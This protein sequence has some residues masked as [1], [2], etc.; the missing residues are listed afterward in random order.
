MD[1]LDE[2]EAFIRVARS[3]SFTG[4]ARERGVTPSALSKQVKALESRLGVRLLQ[5]TTRRV[6]LTDAGRGF[7]ERAETIVGDIE[8][9][10]AAVA[11]LDAEPRGVLR[12]GAPMDFGR[13]HLASSIASF[14]AAHPALQV[15]VELTDRAVD[16][17]EEGLDVDVRIGAL[18]ESSLVARRLAPCHRVVC[19]SP[20]Y[21]DAHG[22][23]ERVE[24]FAAYSRVGYAYETQRTWRFETPSGPKQVNVPVGHRANNGEVTRALLIEGLGVALLPTF[25]VADAVRSGALEMLLAD[26]VTSSIPIHALYPH[27]KQ[28]SAKVRAFVDHLVTHCGPRPY[29]DDG[30][31]LA[32][33]PA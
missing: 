13:L 26:R 23:A 10:E 16:L 18:R 4:A 28:L 27:R 21:L 5:R 3:G 32:S 31:A 7:L 15:E 24:D 22:R 8:D 6:S 25:I 29:W 9:A 1:R 2:Y 17:I 14:A 30:L 20:A 11:D 12:V 19:A 33:A